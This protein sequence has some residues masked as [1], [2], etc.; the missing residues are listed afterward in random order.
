MLLEKPV[1]KMYTKSGCPYC[2]KAR[3]MILEDL[4]ASLHLVDISNQQD[5]RDAIVTETGQKTVP[6]IFIGDELIGGYD[7]L[8]G[9]VNTGQ[10]KTKVLE[11][12]NKILRD[13]VIRLRRSL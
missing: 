7:D 6:V 2:D 8:A 3:K 13:E 10:V 9:L 12:E 11:A 1:F 4:K 5:L